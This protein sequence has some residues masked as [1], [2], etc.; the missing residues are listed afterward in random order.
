LKE[1]RKLLNNGKDFNEWMT[2]NDIVD[3]TGINKNVFKE[4][5]IKTAFID[6]PLKLSNVNIE[7]E[8][9]LLYNSNRKLYRV[10]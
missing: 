10:L 3:D 9:V 2:F 1:Y 5:K 6:E 7:N 4:S 8:Y